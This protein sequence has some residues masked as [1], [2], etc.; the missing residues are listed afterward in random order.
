MAHESGRKGFKGSV[1]KVIEHSRR[2]AW[3]PKGTVR[4]EGKKGKRGRDV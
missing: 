1:E 4:E 3:G 2:G